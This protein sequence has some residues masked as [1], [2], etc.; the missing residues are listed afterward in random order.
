MFILIKSSLNFLCVAHSLF[1]P[2]PL[3]AVV[4]S[5][6]YGWSS[7]L[8]VVLPGLCESGLGL[9]ESGRSGL[10]ESGLVCV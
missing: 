3:R 5:G 10:C 1:S 9:C 6:M 8:C 7:M 4:S 2:P